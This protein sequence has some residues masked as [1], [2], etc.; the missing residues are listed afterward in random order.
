MLFFLLAQATVQSAPALTPFEFRGMTTYTTESEAVQRGVVTSCQRYAIPGVRECPLVDHS[1]A[2]TSTLFGTTQFRN[3]Q[4]VYV[5]ALVSPDEFDRVKA[6][7]VERYGQPCLQDP[8][9]S[10][11]Q[12]VGH[13]YYWCFSDGA[14]TLEQIS[15]GGMSGFSFYARSY[16]DIIADL[17]PKVDF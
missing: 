1:L 7:L 10:R 5:G 4:L 8:S 9:A 15:T 17:R 6:A 3:G 16:D 13:S 2:G 14:A 11:M 12:K